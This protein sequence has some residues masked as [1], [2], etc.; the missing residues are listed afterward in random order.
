MT[1]SGPRR[2]FAAAM[3]SSRA[4]S[5]TRRYESKSQPT[6]ASISGAWRVGG[7]CAPMRVLLSEMDIRLP[8]DCVSSSRGC[9]S[10]VSGPCLGTSFSHIRCKFPL[11]PDEYHGAGGWYETRLID[12]MPLL[13]FRDN[14]ANV[15]GQV[16]V[17]GS[18]TQQRPQIMI[19]LAEK[20]GAELA[21][22]SQPDARAMTAEGLCHR[23]DEADFAG[24]AIGKAVLS[25]G[26]AAFVGDLL[27]RPAGVDTA[28]DFGGG[29]NQATSPVAVGIERHEFDKAHDD[30]GFAGEQSEGFDFVVVDA[31]DQDG[32][33][34]GGGQA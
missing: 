28:V 15:S 33:H 12:S 8:M 26:F 11:S 16:L 4:V 14:R 23:C 18:F 32:I 20:T 13:F 9:C 27:D 31:A 22:G 2:A 29:N 5:G 30:A 25:S 1:T 21:V 7:W 3:R 6:P 19:V 34:L 10:A 24:R 17:G